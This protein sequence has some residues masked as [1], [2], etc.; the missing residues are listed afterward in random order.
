MIKIRPRK[1]NFDMYKKSTYEK[2]EQSS[3]DLENAQT[4]LKFINALYRGAL[5]LNWLTAREKDLDRLIQKGCD[6]LIS[7]FGYPNVWIALSDDQNRIGPIF[8]AGFNEDFAPM[9]AYLREGKAPPC[10]SHVLKGRGTRRVHNRS[11]ECGDCPLALAYGDTGAMAAGLE[12]NGEFYGLIAVS[13][14]SVFVEDEDNLRIF[15]EIAEGISYAVYRIHLREERELQRAKLLE[16]E[17]MLASIFKC[18]PTG[19]GVTQGKVFRHANDT[20]CEMVGYSQEELLGK[21]ERMIYPDDKTFDSAQREKCR[22]IGEQKT[23]TIETRWRRKDGKIIE[24]LLTVSPFETYSRSGDTIFT[25]LDITETKELEADRRRLERAI[26]QAFDMVVITD[27][28]GTIRYVNPAFEKGT[29]YSREEALGMDIRILE[30]GEQQDEPFYRRVWQVIASG[31]TW[32]GRLVTRKKD[33]TVFTEQAIITPIFSES[34]DLVNYI[35]IRRDISDQIRIEGQLQHAAKM[36]AIGTL[37]GGITHDFNNLLQVI[38]GYVQILLMEKEPDDP[39]LKHLKAIEKATRG[40]SDLIQQLLAF[41]RKLETQKRPLNLNQKVRETVKL[42]RK[43][44]PR[45]I[46][47]SVNTADN[48]EMINA[49]PV[50]MEQILLNLAVNARDAMP[51]GGKLLIETENVTLEGECVI[52]HFEP[53][54]GRYVLLSVSDT[55]H[56]MDKDTLEHIFEP[57]YT[58]KEVGKG[59]GLGL[60]MVYGIVKDH[61][62]HIICDSKPGEGTIFRLYFPVL[63]SA[64]PVE[65]MENEEDMDIPGGNETILLVDDDNM[66]R[67]FERGTLVKY[68]YNVLEADSGE[69]ALEVYRKRKEDI[70]LII[71]DLN[72]PGMGGIRCFD[73]LLRMDPAVKVLISTGYSIDGRERE[74]LMAR[75]VEFIEKPFGFKQML[76]RVREILDQPNGT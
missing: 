47:I 9:A 21:S 4:K 40:A 32:Q 34:G 35:A 58:T 75:A 2:G 24:V 57:F 14:P 15:S 29:G 49:D 73:E 8:N 7:G 26:D 16:T 69:Q 48:L 60:S 11:S 43:T 50:Q 71:L 31:K 61:G 74:K 19:I 72:M 70:S 67:D 37:T 68:G 46:D 55:G 22:Q 54:T 52:T 45:M 64:G 66:I 51:G 63:R 41:S 28:A 25:A 65:G 20:L 23:A 6:S 13:S 62:G 12:H 38:Y 53:V 30:S 10:W 18:V 1:G 5:N 33:G 17:A 3:E 44:I 42:L 27:A 59:T 56:G 76:K 39:D 36:E